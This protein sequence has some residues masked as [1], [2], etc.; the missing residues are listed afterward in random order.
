MGDVIRWLGVGL[1]SI[2]LVA[3]ARAEEGALHA[4]G[5]VEAPMLDEV[6][7]SGRQPGPGLWQVRKDGHTM[8]VLGTLDPL[9]RRM[10]WDSAA[11]EAKVASATELVQM[12]RARVTANV[13]LFSGLAMLPKALGARRNPDK[14]RL[15]DVLPAPVY[16]RFAALRAKYLGRNRSVD[17]QRPI[18]AAGRLWA[19]ALFRAGLREHDVVSPVLRRVAKRHKLVL[20]QP[21]VQMQIEDPKQALEEFRRTALDD[22]PCM[23][24][25]LDRIESDLGTMQARANAWAAGDLERLRML[26]YVD[27]RRACNDAFLQAQMAKDR[28]LDDLRERTRAAWLEA[29][30]TAIARNERSFGVLSIREVL[31]ADGLLTTLRAEGYEVIPPAPPATE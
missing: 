3:A 2:M 13:G 29:A 27:Q 28:G 31:A 17:K 1:G 10:R 25:T 12:P 7:V 22:V 30:R 15:Q 23:T 14:E 9:P 20:T 19:R 6:V 8:W 26:P 5:E 4:P 21:E 11:V 16:A 24:Q 18:V